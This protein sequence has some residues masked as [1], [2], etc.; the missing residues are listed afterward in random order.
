MF[1]VSVQFLSSLERRLK[2][3]E[4]ELESLNGDGIETAAAKL[5]AEYTDD[6]DQRL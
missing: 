2:A 1:P 4:L 6:L 5:V 3:Y